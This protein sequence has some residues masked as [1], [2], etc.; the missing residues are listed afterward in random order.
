VIRLGRIETRIILFMGVFIL[1][2]FILAPGMLGTNAVSGLFSDVHSV[3]F[4]VVD[5]PFY[6]PQLLEV[7]VSYF[8]RYY[9][10]YEVA[11]TVYHDDTCIADEA[12]M[13]RSTASK[14]QTES[15]HTYIYVPKAGSYTIVFSPEGSKEIDFGISQSLSRTAFS[16][17][18]VIGGVLAT[19]AVVAVWALFWRRKA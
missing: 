3:Q 1:G 13:I 6:E 9:E 11:V 16:Y 8:M 17:M 4:N 10:T 14:Q 2:A 7:R 12:L 15:A 18:L 5:S 19:A